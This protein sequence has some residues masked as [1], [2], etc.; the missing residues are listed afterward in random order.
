M[1]SIVTLYQ[2]GNGIYNL[3]DKVL[4][5]DQG[6]QVY[7]GPATEAKSFMEELGFVCRDGAN[8]ADFLTGLTVPTERL[9]RSGHEHKFPRDADSLRDAYH[10]SLTS[11]QM[12]AELDYPSTEHA[13]NNTAQFK[14]RVRLE[15]SRQLPAS[16]P[17]TVNFA[18]QARAAVIRQYQILWGDK[19]TFLIKQLS[20][21]AQA[22][23]TGSLFYQAPDNSSG[24]FL[25]SGALFFSILFHSLMAMSEVTDSFHGRPILAKHK[26]FAMYH[27]AAFCIAQITA[28]IPIILFQISTFSVILYFMVGLTSSASAF[29][30]YWALLFAVTMVGLPPNFHRGTELTRPTGLSVSRLCSGSLRP[31]SRRLMGPPRYPAWSSVLW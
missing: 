9:I 3:F 4:V 24:L 13:S 27:P 6:K 5:L 12:K 11:S 30:T 2:A 1:S 21:I 7:Y 10:R 8:V 16:S 19:A 15:K 28:D 25:K 26:A 20:T 23:I 18:V 31:F 14:E 17:L 29:L 22:L